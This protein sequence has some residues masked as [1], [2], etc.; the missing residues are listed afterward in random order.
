MNREAMMKAGCA[1]SVPIGES[2]LWRV[3]KI[4]VAH[5]MPFGESGE[6]CPKGNYTA[7]LRWTEG[8][9]P[10]TNGETVMAD[11]PIELRKHVAFAMAARGN[12]LVTGL[13][14]ACVARMLQQNPRVNCITI[15]E[16]SDDVIKLVWPHT[17]HEKIE[18]VRADAISFLDGT[19]RHWDCAW[20]DI[21]V[22]EC[23][24]E[25]HLSVVHLGMMGAVADR[26]KFQGAWEL[27]RKYKR[28]FNR[29]IRHRRLEAVV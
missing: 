4:N 15:V 8:H 20:H 13:G 14:L 27:P 12:V 17:S 3:E 7:L 23:A 10:P 5:A 6:I 26:V 22:D 11:N 2:G 16:N 9:P 21:W 19:D 25:P 24:G 29:A 1:A 18:L 28:D